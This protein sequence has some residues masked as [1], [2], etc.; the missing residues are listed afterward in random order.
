[1]ISRR[2]FVASSSTAMLAGCAGGP[3]FPS[4]RRRCNRA[5][6]PSCW[7]R[8][9]SSATGSSCAWWVCARSGQ[10]GFV[11]RAEPVGTK[12]VAHSYGH[13]GGGVTLSWGTGELAVE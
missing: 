8:P 1:M 6:R 13:G 5:A 7:R 10:G 12:R 4:C 9:T 11:V 2:G 3:G